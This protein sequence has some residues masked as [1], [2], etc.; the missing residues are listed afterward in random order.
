MQPINTISQRIH[1]FI[2]SYFNFNFKYL[3]KLSTF[4]QFAIQ[5][6]DLRK[7]QLIHCLKQ[8]FSTSNKTLVYPHLFQH[9][10]KRD[11]NIIFNISYFNK[12]CSQFCGLL[13]GNIV[14]CQ[15]IHKSI[16][17]SPALSMKG[18][19]EFIIDFNKLTLLS[20]N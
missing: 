12:C 13:C 15:S 3:V 1:M 14:Y 9:Q 11:K 19:D 5:F 8:N 10:T 6:S 20:T 16:A 2:N 7:P 4:P 18:V 17:L